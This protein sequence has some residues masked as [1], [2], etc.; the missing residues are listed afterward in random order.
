MRYVRT[1]TEEEHDELARMIRLDSTALI[2]E[3]RLGYTTIHAKVAQ[4]KQRRK[5]TLL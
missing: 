5:R 3:V 2:K 1:V 4:E